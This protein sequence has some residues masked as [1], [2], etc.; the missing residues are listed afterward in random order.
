MTVPLGVLKAG[1]IKFTPALPAGYS[2][3]ISRLGMGVLNKTY[4]RF[5]YRFWDNQEQLLGYIGLERGRWAEWYDFQRITNQPILLGFNAGSFASTL[6]AYSDAQT[7]SSAMSVLRAI[8]GASV[9]DPV[10]YKITRWGKNPFSFGSYSFVGLGSSPRDCDTLASP[11]N[12]KLIFAG[13]HTIKKY[14]GTA[15][16][17]Y[18]SGLNAS[19][20]V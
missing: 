4:L 1:A 13:E 11:V 19:A 18:R 17:A 3:A 9:P 2:A 5:P 15:H 16:G 20:K 10:G 6:E 8:Y 12:S 14:I 7:V